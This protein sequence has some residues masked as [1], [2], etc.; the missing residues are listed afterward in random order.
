MFDFLRDHRFPEPDEFD[1]DDADAYLAH[2][3]QDDTLP[4]EMR[5]AASSEIGVL[6]A[7]GAM[8]QFQALRQTYLAWADAIKEYRRSFA[9]AAARRN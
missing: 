3:A 1:A 4:V 6:S 2:V 7:V 9:F 8:G 5:M